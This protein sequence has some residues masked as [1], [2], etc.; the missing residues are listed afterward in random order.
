MRA[1]YLLSLC[2][3]V[4]VCVCVCI[5]LQ[6]PEAIAEYQELLD[7]N[8]AEPGFLS[9]TAQSVVE[10]KLADAKQLLSLMNRNGG[11]KEASTGV[12]GGVGGG[13]GGGGGGVGTSAPAEGAGFW[14]EIS[15][16]PLLGGFCVGG[17]KPGSSP[18][19][20]GGGGGFG[21]R[22]HPWHT[23]NAA[24]GRYKGG[25]AGVAAPTGEFKTTDDTGPGDL[26]SSVGEKMTDGV[27]TV[28]AVGVGMGK[29][30][31][32]LG[33]SAI[34]LTTQAVGKTVQMVPNIGQGVVDLG[35]DVGKKIKEK[36]DVW[37]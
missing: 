11:R 25:D 18:N 1:P 20:P 10:R 14:K 22:H 17:R 6:V 24:S 3:C 5:W 12:S 7:R 15:T 27:A 19:T 26:M 21:G 34:D 23:P 28:G 8:A 32:K 29:L 35:V 2:V 31:L 33:G 4:C 30:G 16:S 9:E 13:G 37:I 36:V